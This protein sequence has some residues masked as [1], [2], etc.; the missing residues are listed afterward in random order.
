MKY[1]LIILAFCLIGCASITVNPETGEF[2]YRRLGD[3]H[4]QGLTIDRTDNK[5]VVTLEGQASK[6]TAL[7]D[8]IH[9]LGG[10]AGKAK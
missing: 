6:A 10:L 4:I 3:Q 2:T 9:V 7:S 8:A 1:L 5:I